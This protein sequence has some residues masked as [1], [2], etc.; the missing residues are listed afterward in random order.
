VTSPG[1]A[2]ELDESRDSAD[3]ITGYRPVCSCGWSGEM[4]TTEEFSDLTPTGTGDPETDA[5]ATAHQAGVVHRY[6]V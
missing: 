1:H 2:V 5:Y 4:S 3:K 6:S